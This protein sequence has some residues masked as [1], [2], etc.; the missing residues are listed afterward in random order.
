METIKSCGVVSKEVAVQMAEGLQRV[1]GS[2]I[3]VSV[4]GYAGPDGD[5]VGL[6]YIGLCYKGKTIAV[7]KRAFK[8]SREF[9]RGHA[10]HEMFAEIYTNGL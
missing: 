2:D 1:T 5:D 8:Y 3:C 4:T 9:I 7:C 10:V 6:Y